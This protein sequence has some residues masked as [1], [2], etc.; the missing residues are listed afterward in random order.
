MVLK[1]QKAG[2]DGSRTQDIEE[3][4]TTP[5]GNGAFNPGFEIR[6]LFRSIFLVLRQLIGQFHPTELAAR[7]CVVLWRQPVWIIKAT[8]R[9]IDLV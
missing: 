5:L 6:L 2:E 8:R 4:A 9:D 1:P 7:A 3:K